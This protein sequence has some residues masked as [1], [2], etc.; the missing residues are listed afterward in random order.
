MLVLS[1]CIPYYNRYE[2][3]RTNLRSILR[4]QSDEFEVLIIDNGSTEDIR[5]KLRICDPRIRIIRRDPVVSGPRNINESV[6]LGRGKYSLLCIDKN[7]ILGEYLDSF[8]AFLK[9]NPQI[10]GGICSYYMTKEEAL[11]KAAHKVK[12]YKNAPVIKFGYL[13]KHPTGNFYLTQ[14][15][16]KA[17]D[18]FSE[19]EKENTFGYDLLL[20]ECAF[21]GEM[22]KYD[23]PLMF[24]Q[25]GLE[26]ERARS[27]SFSEE[28]GNLYFLPL[29]AIHQ[30]NVYL[31]HLEKQKCM[32]ITRL[33]VMMHLYRLTLCHV[34]ID[35]RDFIIDPGACAHYHVHCRT[36]VGK[37]ELIANCCR[38]NRFFL[39][40]N[41]MK[42]K[43]LR[44]AISFIVNL[45]FFI[46]KWRKF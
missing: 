39:K 26:S 44:F 37:K 4:A 33:R 30:F 45:G 41:F 28:K 32:Y 3:L 35:Y 24:S 20:S 13:S 9:D 17:F 5:K 14:C 25:Q 19:E 31:N 18:H 11:H 22:I 21:H 8:C 34:S 6:T 15:A 40:S 38:L 10:Y 46:D 2:S 36:N 1:I 23:F 42:H 12:L 7:Y 43:V 29:N 16:K 27:F